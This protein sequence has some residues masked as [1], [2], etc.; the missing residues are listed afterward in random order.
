M[1][2]PELYR[3]DLEIVRNTAAQVIKDFGL[4]GI[5]IAFSGNPQTAY[6]ELL[7]QVTPG[8][9]LLY[10]KQ[11][12]TFMMLL[13]R[14]DVEESRVKAIMNQ[15]T[16]AGSFPKLAELVLE[17]EFIKVVLRKLYSPPSV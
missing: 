5:E 2:T 3:H 11:N 15:G 12:K 9:E 16:T 1:I 7:Q 10:K 13:Y 4:A 14:I 8:L 6:Q 17:R